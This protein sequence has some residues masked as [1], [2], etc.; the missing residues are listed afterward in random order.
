MRNYGRLKK[1]SKP[2]SIHVAEFSFHA[3]SYFLTFVTASFLQNETIKNETVYEKDLLIA[4][5][6]HGFSFL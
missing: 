3:G 5:R 6:Y 1:A 2:F 4:C